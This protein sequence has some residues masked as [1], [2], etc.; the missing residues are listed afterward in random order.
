MNKVA[1]VKI[2]KEVEKLIS[3]RVELGSNPYEFEI[4]GVTGYGYD[5]QTTAHIAYEKIKK[6]VERSGGEIY[7]NKDEYENILQAN[8]KRLE[9]KTLLQRV[10]GH[11]EACQKGQSQGYLLVEIYDPAARIIEKIKGE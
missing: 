1:G 2:S 4:R 3:E 9:N 5:L 6:W 11:R 7:L 8:L 10:T